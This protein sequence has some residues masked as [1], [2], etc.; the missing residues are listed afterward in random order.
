MFSETKSLEHID[1]HRCSL[2]VTPQMSRFSCSAFTQGIVRALRPQTIRFSTKGGFLPLQRLIGRGMKEACETP[3]STMKLSCLHPT[4]RI[5]KMKTPVHI[6]DDVMVSNLIWLSTAHINAKEEERLLMLQGEEKAEKEQVQKDKEEKEQKKKEKKKLKL[7]LKKE[8]EKKEKENQGN[9]IIKNNDATIEDDNNND[10]D[11]NL[12]QSS[13]DEENVPYLDDDD[14]GILDS[15]GP[16]EL[17]HASVESVQNIYI[18]SSQQ[19]VDYAKKKLKQFEI[20]YLSTQLRPSD[21]CCVIYLSFEACG[22]DRDSRY[23]VSSSSLLMNALHSNRSVTDLNLSNNDIGK[24]HD[25]GTSLQ[26]L[27]NR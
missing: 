3:S 9:K 18:S 26:H 12:S 23:L 13:S 11:N 10:D 15:T 1:L 20:S 7:K 17:I 8:Q 24:H 22:L 14:D 4:T 27:L 16:H 21:T 19:L 2:D 6:L 5:L 25:C